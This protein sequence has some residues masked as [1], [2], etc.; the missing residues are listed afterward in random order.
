MET[1]EAMES[2]DQPLEE[3]T[4]Q[5]EVESEESDTSAEEADQPEQESEDP[6]SDE[7]RER[8]YMRDADYRRKTQELAEM[9]REIEAI[10]S[11]L[12]KPVAERTPEEQNA[13]ST[14]EK[15]GVARKEDVQSM[16]ERAMAREKML[17]EQSKIKSEYGFDDDMMFVV[18]SLAITK[19]IQLS[20]AAKMIPTANK[21]VV[22][23]KS[24]G[25]KG[26]ISTP[27]TNKKSEK[28]KPLS[29]MSDAEFDAYRDSMGV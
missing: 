26:G 23:R 21:K 28:I 5:P 6:I 27:S 4:D 9:R 12:T 29:E 17:L 7:E 24:V 8:G 11:G 2:N 15:L 1:E 22:N 16:I 18:Q 10:K 14:L 20:E 19:Q 13:L 3:S 25:L